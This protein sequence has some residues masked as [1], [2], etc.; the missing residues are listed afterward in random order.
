M[1]LEGAVVRPASGTMYGQAL[2]TA[3]RQNADKDAFLRLLTAQMQYQDPLAPM[4]NTQMVAQL[5]QF[6][7]LEQ[8]QHLHALQQQQTAVALLGEH[9]GGVD[10]ETQELWSGTVT[11][12][13]FERGMPLLQVGSRLVTL[14]DIGLVGDDRPGDTSGGTEEAAS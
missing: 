6:T 12:V 10:A 13:F 7:T 9:V 14:A 5:A 4:D 2:S 11:R 1:Q 3:G 8:L